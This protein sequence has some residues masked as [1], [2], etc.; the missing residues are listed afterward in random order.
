[1]S[2]AI[3]QVTKKTTRTTVNT[4]GLIFP[5]TK[6]DI[7][8]TTETF[9]YNK[10]NIHTREMSIRTEL[11]NHKSPMVKSKFVPLDIPSSIYEVILVIDKIKQG[12]KCNNITK[13]ENMFSFFRECLKG[14]AKRQFEVLKAKNLSLSANTLTAVKKE[15][16][17]Y[18]CVK[19][20]LIHQQSYMRY[21]LQP[22]VGKTVSEFVYTATTLNNLLGKLPP[23]YN[24]SQSLLHGE[25]L[26]TD[27]QNA[28]KPYRGIV[29]FHS[30]KLGDRELADYIEIC[31]RA[32]VHPQSNN[33]SS[34]ENNT[35]RTKQKSDRK[36]KVHKTTKQDK[37]KNERPR[38]S[39]QNK[40]DF[41]C[42]HHGPNDT[43]S[44]KDCYT[45]KNAK[46]K[47]KKSENMD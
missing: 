42:A 38:T 44:S 28:E 8:R 23:L 3:G 33:N 9:E 32:T 21:K 31:K 47:R 18:F 2:T 1:M 36:K 45:L 13:G 12:I 39:K 37:A 34:V 46:E 25:F 24:A 30:F 43:H 4:S 35:R 20:I 7:F 26:Y 19:D 16:V 5:I 17:E 10:N 29:K 27:H 11:A 6:E 22:P 14:E 41:Y 40:G 15:L